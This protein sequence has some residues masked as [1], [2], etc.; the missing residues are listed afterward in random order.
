MESLFVVAE[1][2]IELEIYG[3]GGGGE[4][5]A[6]VQFSELGDLSVLSQGWGERLRKGLV[7]LRLPQHLRLGH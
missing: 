3:V 6:L 2:G 5:L 4:E 1:E 7:R